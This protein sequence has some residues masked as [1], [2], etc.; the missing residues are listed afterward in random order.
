MK[1]REEFF[2]DAWRWAC[3]L[4]PTED[5][6]KAIPDLDTLVEL[7]W[8]EPFEEECRKLT[9]PSRWDEEFVMLCKARMIQG[10]FRYG[11]MTQNER[12]DPSVAV[13]SIPPRIRKFAGSGDLTLLCDAANFSLVAFY[14]WTKQN[15]YECTPAL[16]R[17]IHF[18]E[19]RDIE[20]IVQNF[21][22]QFNT[23]HNL[24]QL[25]CIF[26]F[27]M[28]VFKLFKNVKGFA[29]RDSETEKVTWDG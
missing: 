13:S 7:Q 14:N 4:P 25:C 20:R 2:L 15:K 9:A 10:A 8:F 26:T 18:R 24:M 1:S 5:R 19:A 6:W 11:T 16:M 28:T 12:K 27:C 29:V 3:N 17:A 22:D 23:T 21:V